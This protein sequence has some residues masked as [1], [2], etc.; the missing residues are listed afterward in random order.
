[1]SKLSAF[2]DLV[3]RKGPVQASRAAARWLW[4]QRQ[5][6][7]PELQRLVKTHNQFYFDL[8]GVER[9]AAEA[10]LEKAA[11]RAR[12]TLGPNDSVHQLAFAALAASGF[13]PEAVL[14]L[15]TSH[16]DTTA[17]LA[18]LYPE[19]TIYTVELPDD[20][21]IYER[22][23]PS[24]DRRNDRAARLEAYTNIRSLRINTLWLPKQELP[25]FDLIWLDAGHHFPEVAWDHF[26][27]INKLKPGGWLFT[28][29]VMKE[30]SKLAR[31]NPAH[32][33]V[34]TVLRYLDERLEENF[35]MLLKREVPQQYVANI[36]YVGAL[37]IEA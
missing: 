34:W 29:D 16:G 24:H 32:F 13:R 21:P 22:S 31:K 12:V 14:E 37:H 27:C 4:V 2:T 18:E 28:D 10:F 9:A 20:D 3:R 26:Y 35:H 7:D 8:L 30:E 36:K 6:R 5:A 17:I 19:S 15:G 25:D 33:D 23:H 11:A 1:M